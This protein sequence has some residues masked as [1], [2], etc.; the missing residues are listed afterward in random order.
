MEEFVEYSILAGDYDAAVNT[1]T[2]NKQTQAAKT[3]RFTQ[4]AGGFPEKKVTE[5]HRTVNEQDPNAP[6][7]ISLFE[8]GPE[9]VELKHSTDT[10]SSKL[11]A[12]NAPL[13]SAAT[14]LSLGD[15]PCGIQKLMLANLPEF[16]YAIAKESMPIAVDQVLVAL[17]NKT[18]FYEQMNLTNAIL[19]KVKNQRL[20]DVLETS[21]YV[22]SA[23]DNGA[24]RSQRSTSNDGAT[25]F[26]HIVGQRI[27]E[28]VQATI[29]NYNNC[30]KV[31]QGQNHVC[32]SKQ[33]FEDH[34]FLSFIDLDNVH[35]K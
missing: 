20:M 9:Q 32:L 19:Q 29:T 25:V 21:L 2:A 14:H 35:S 34:Y 33:S 11:Y 27:E 12:Q 23:D 24:I 16:A 17:F 28:A 8:L 7:T 6:P 22:N 13:L 10:E 4:L 5:R 3:L 26:D 31:G 18:E 15:V 1:L 30:N